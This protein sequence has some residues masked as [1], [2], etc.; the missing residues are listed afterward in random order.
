MATKKFDIAVKVGEYTNKAG[1]TK[2][3]WQ[4]VGAMMEGESGPF[5][6]LAKWFNPA[7]V[8]DARGGE[9][10]LLSLFEPKQYEN[11]DGQGK[12]RQQPA[13]RGSDD[14]PSAA[15]TAAM[16]RSAKAGGPPRADN[17][18]PF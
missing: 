13:V 2:G 10:I 17:E 5:I 9:S 4:N 8:V 7:G 16:Q 15:R 11:G 3:R 1:E 14:V 18:I 6:M 12:Q